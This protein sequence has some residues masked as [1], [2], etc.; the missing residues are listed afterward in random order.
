[1]K[2]DVKQKQV[3]KNC[4]LYEALPEENREEI[5]SSFVT[6]SFKKAEPI[7][8]QYNFIKSLGVILEGEAA[9]YNESGAILNVLKPGNCFGAAALF[10]PAE[11]YV[12]SI[13][14]KKQSLI[15]FISGSELKEL[16]LKYPQTALSYISFLSGRIQF[17]N[18]K[19]DSFTSPSIG[20]AVWNWLLSQANDS[21]EVQ[22]AMGY[23]ALAR[24]LSVSRASLYRALTELQNEGKIVKNG[25]EIKIC[26][27]FKQEDKL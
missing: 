19:I 6:G 26:N 21:G 23:A 9:V 5:F 24:S 14:A 20:N 16:F 12:T 11:E 27:R 1:M 22:I 7:Y 25:A 4:F 17:L 10:S 18:R 15:L 13:V 2:L 8:T 3:L